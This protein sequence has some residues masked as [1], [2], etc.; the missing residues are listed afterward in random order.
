MYVYCKTGYKR[1]KWDAV[2]K[3]REFNVMGQT[4]K[5]LFMALVCPSVSKY[6]SLK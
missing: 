6:I 1:K 5:V 2:L 3:K 4:A